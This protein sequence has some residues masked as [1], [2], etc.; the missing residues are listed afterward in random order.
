MDK[1]K[2]AYLIDFDN[3]LFDTEKLKLSISSS[4]KEKFGSKKLTKFWNC[5][6]SVCRNLG[7][8]DIHQIALKCQ[9]TFKEGT[10]DEYESLFLKQNFKKFVFK[11]T[12]KTIRTLKKMG[13]TILY[14]LGDDY[15]QPIKIEKSGIGRFIGKKNIHITK[16]KDKILGVRLLD[17]KSQGYSTIIL[18]DDKAEILEKAKKIDPGIITVWYRYGKYKNTQPKQSLSID[19][20][21]TSQNELVYYLENF[22]AKIK[23]NC[24]EDNISVQRGITKDMTSQL[25]KLTSGDKK[26]IKLTH[27]RERFKSLGTFARWKS[28]GK[29]IYTMSGT[30]GKLLGIIWFSKK[31]IPGEFPKNYTYTF[32]IR[33]YKPARGKGLSSRFMQIVFDDFGVGVKRNIWLTTNKE[34]KAAIKLYKNYGFKMLGETRDYQLLYV[35]NS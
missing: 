7:C 35:Y 11:N 24:V 28:R 15:Y 21:F 8:I 1:Q 9:K 4:F 30:K 25:I 27:D 13:K 14:T 20:E 2:R 12:E 19:K 22:V 5:Y 31:S 18:I 29:Y 3:T 10:V 6:S 17:L 34:N 33:N 23:Q 16:D 26:I 32:A